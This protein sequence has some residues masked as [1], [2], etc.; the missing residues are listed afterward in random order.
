MTMI[1]PGL[2][3]FFPGQWQALTPHLPTLPGLSGLLN[4]SRRI[5]RNPSSFEA[6]LSTKF[7]LSI[8][9]PLPIAA[10][11][12]WHDK[13]HPPSKSTLRADPVYLKVDRDC[14]F[15]LGVQALQVS[16]DEAKALATQINQLYSDTPWSME[17]GAAD[18]WYVT[19]EEEFNLKTYAITE[20]FGKNIDSY[21]PQGP[22]GKK[23]R[24]V[25][26]EIQMLLHNSDINLQRETNR[27]LPI[28][29][30]WL[31]GEGSLPQRPT[32]RTC[33]ID[34]VW[35]NESLCRGLAHWAQCVSQDLPATVSEWSEH[36]QAGRH[37]IVFDD[38]RV[39]AKEDFQLWEK[40]LM[41]WDEVWFSPLYEAV[42]NRQLRLNIEIDKGLVFECAATLWNKW[43]LTKRLWH[44]WFQ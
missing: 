11:T 33:N 14:L 4:Q 38:I 19:A 7:G 6:M 29:S 35:S 3:A 15:M 25:L 10:L 22:A 40:K 28:N 12:Y 17:I 32:N 5:S 9:Q 30:V 8:H 16:P 18:R 13:G 26:N 34:Y 39:L 1:I 27:R 21:L 23:W 24:A 2:T 44:E 20:V 41:E 42:K 36:R 43:R 37:L 31:W